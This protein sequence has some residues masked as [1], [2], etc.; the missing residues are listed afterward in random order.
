MARRGGWGRQRRPPGRCGEENRYRCSAFAKVLDDVDTAL[1]LHNR[2][3]VDPIDHLQPHRSMLIGVTSGV[4]D[5]VG[6]SVPCAAGRG[7][8][9]G[10]AVGLG[11]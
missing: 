9:P 1:R 3:R 8:H 11:G 6:V 7:D 10:P 4:M 2:Y 5:V